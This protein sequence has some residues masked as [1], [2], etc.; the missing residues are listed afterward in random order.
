M[1]PRGGGPAAQQ[2][3]H[4]LPAPQRPAR[5]AGTGGRR[6]RHGAVLKLANRSEWFGN[7]IFPK[8][9]SETLA[10]SDQ[11]AGRCPFLTEA[12]KAKTPCVKA[13]N[14]LGVCTISAASNGPRQDWLVCPYRALDD[15]LLADIARRLYSI[16]VLEPVLIRPVVAL[17]DH[18]SRSEILAAVD[19][20]RRVFVYF[21][22]KLGGEIGLSR[23]AAS[24]ELSFDITM[25]ELIPSVPAADTAGA[26]ESAVSVGRYGVFELQTMDF[27][28]T[29]KNAVS[30]L[31]NALDLHGDRFPAVLAD[32]P[33]WAG[34]GIEG[35]NISN[36]FK[37]TFYQIAFKF[38][39]TKRETSVGCALAL[40]Q[41]VWDSWQ[42]FLGAPDLHEHA[43]GTYRLLDDQEARPTDW[44][45][46]FDIDTEPGLDGRPAPLRIS[47]VIGTDAAAERGSVRG[48]LSSASGMGP[49]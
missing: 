16:P 9:S 43:D 26:Y 47:L 19:G 41:P 39:V 46:V 5:P 6:P 45:Y 21:Q 20:D 11:R 38:Q 28:G 35:P 49:G 27:H 36:V 14:S 2:P 1:R 30:A 13:P 15:G 33:E 18:L 7:R 17:G 37:R 3:G 40:P 34:R 22:D 23:T 31:A 12:L 24:P 10:M 48:G 8:V 42:P 44:I 32:N 4:V 29:Y 25:V